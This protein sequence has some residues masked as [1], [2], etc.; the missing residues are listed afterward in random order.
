M[1]LNASQVTENII[2]MYRAVPR[3]A[4]S[5]PH[6]SP[7]TPLPRMSADSSGGP[8][9]AGR[10]APLRSCHVAVVGAGA[11][12]L[13]AIAELLAEGHTVTAFEQ[14]I[15]VPPPAA[16]VCEPICACVAGLLFVRLFVR[17]FFHSEPYL[18]SLRTRSFFTPN[19]ILFHSEPDLFSL[20]TRSFFTPNPI[21]FHSEPDLFS[22]RTRLVQLHHDR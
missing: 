10:A 17:L 2:H 6:P 22:L 20:R 21:V 19:P 4:L 16:R 3:I 11:A 18:F 5:S 12:G 14:A 7:P 1:L 15:S 13:A 8:P 9:P